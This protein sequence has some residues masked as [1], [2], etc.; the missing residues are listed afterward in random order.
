MSK[1]KIEVFVICRTDEIWP[2]EAKAFSLSRRTAEGEVRP[3]PIVITRV[4]ARNFYGYVNVCPHEHS[5]L[6]FNAGTFLTADGKALQCGRHGA[7]FDIASGLCVAGKC[8]GQSL[9]PLAL[10]V[11]AGDVC[12]C[13]EPLVADERTEVANEYDDTMEI[14]IHPG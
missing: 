6:N 1:D 12:L 13:G 14:M 3:F 8:A 5:W 7:Q 9:T 2:G 11:I 4:G 10:A